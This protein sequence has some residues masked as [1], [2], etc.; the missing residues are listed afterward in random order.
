MYKIEAVTQAVY[1]AVDVVNEMFP[2]GKRLQ[3]S[4]ETALHGE[5][6]TLDSLGIV[7]FIV[8]IEERISRDLGVEISLS[9]ETDNVENILK[10]I[11]TL[12]KYIV[13]KV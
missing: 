4:S 3:K 9:E 1:G 12:I 8:A 6:S 2:E 11:G 10:N 13:G 7:C 5:T